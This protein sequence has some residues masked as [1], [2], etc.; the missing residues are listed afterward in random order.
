MMTMIMGHD[1]WD[2]SD[3]EMMKLLRWWYWETNSDQTF[4]DDRDKNNNDADHDD[5]DNTD[6]EDDIESDDEW[7]RLLCN[8]VQSYSLGNEVCVACEAKAVRDHLGDR[9]TGHGVDGKST[10]FKNVITPAC[11]GKWARVRVEDECPCKNGP[12]FIFV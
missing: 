12:H 1:R 7:R 5:D 6:D 9:C 11:H 10:R 3:A 8:Y 4:H 2:D